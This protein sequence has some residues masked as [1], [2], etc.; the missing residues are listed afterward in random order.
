[1]VSKNAKIKAT[2]LAIRDGIWITMDLGGHVQGFFM[3]K[4][5]IIGLLF[6]L[7]VD[8]WEGLVGTPVRLGY[9]TDKWNESI[10]DVGH[11]LEDKWLRGKHGD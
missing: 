1:M 4:D 3:S 11:F 9:S 2:R 6:T 7:G 10:M 8:C 5:E